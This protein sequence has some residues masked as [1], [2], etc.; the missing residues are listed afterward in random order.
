MYFKGM[1]LPNKIEIQIVDKAGQPN[2]LANI[3]FGLKIFSLD[4]MW[5]NYTAFRTNSDGY[6]SL[7]QQEI[8]DNTELKNNDYTATS[9]PTNFE[10]YVWDGQLITGLIKST[11]R[12]LE[13]YSDKE[14][15]Q[16][17][18]RGHEVTE[19][20]IPGAMKV[21]NKKRADDIAF[22]ERIK[23]AINDSVQI[24]TDKIKGSWLDVLPKHY[25]F[26]IERIK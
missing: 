1:I 23:D 21:V 25:Q 2:P 18:L 14:F 15:V 19:A 7:T 6:I 22:F 20:S 3:I 13:L 8:I 24:Y 26:V 4:G 16:G 10:L 17:D 9:E 5:Y 11:K 12:L